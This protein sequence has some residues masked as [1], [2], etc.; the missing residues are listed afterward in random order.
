MSHKRKVDDITSA[1]IADAANP[2]AWERVAVVPP[3]SSP[4]PMWYGKSRALPGRRLPPD[5]ENVRLAAAQSRYHARVV[6]YYT[7][8]FHLAEHEAI[9][10][11]Q[12]TFLQFF[13][14]LDE[15]RGEAEWALLEKI[16]R[17]LG[18]NRVRALKSASR[19]AQVVSIEAARSKRQTAAQVLVD[20]ASRE[21][22]AA[23]RKQLHDD[24]AALPEG[25]RHAIQLWLDGFH[26]ADIAQVLGVSVDAIKSRLRD[27]K[28]HLR[29]V[30]TKLD[31]HRSR[32]K[33]R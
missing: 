23:R 22:E 16:A 4:R 10:L 32:V 20:H 12:Q 2:D 30:S 9:E 1:L 8:T 7:R 5:A 27:A 6:S 29:P 31:G 17:T 33:S 25:Q 3:S 28:R 14:M 24:I 15:Y 21:A 18:L 26:Y 13:E 19:S 11:A